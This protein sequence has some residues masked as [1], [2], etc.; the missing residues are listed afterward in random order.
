MAALASLLARMGK[1]VSGS[2]LAEG[3][4][5]A[6]LR[7][8]GITVRLG[9]HPENVGDAEYVVRSSAIPDANPEVRASA[10][11][12]VPSVKLAEAVGEL[13][14][15]RTGVAIAGTHGKTTTTAL[16]AWI[17]DQAG[18]E[19]TALVGADALNF[20][21]SAL[22]GDGPMVVEADEFDRRFLHLSPTVAVVT[23]V[24]PDHLDYFKDL[25]EIRATFQGFVDRLPEDGRLVTCLD[26]ADAARLRTRAD[27]Q[28][29]GFDA[30]ADWR[31]TDYV[32]LEGGGS[33]FTLHNGG[34][35]WPAES[36]LLGEHNAAN[37][38]AALAVADYFGVGLQSAL[39]SLR[40]F[41]GTRRRFE[42]KGRSNGIWV[43]D[44]YA[45]HPTAVAATLRAAR[46]AQRQRPIWVVF[47]P[48]TTNR[49]AALLDEFARAFGDADHVLV[50]PIYR[51]SGRE[52][53]ARPVTSVDLVERIARTGHPDVRFVDTFDEAASAVC[54]AVRSGDLVLTMGAGDVTALSDRLVGELGTT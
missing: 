26:Q 36:G 17:L 49:T 38:L 8:S 45:H 50:L 29:Y 5:I 7:A 25:A 40:H 2:D 24:E 33:R 37:A 23:S 13:M 27:R 32:A 35:S 43:V 19:P 42:T 28:T 1:V 52:A 12:H 9:H 54:A 39:A 16:V 15:G 41:R 14:L 3:P 22:L 48:H 44:D 21:S 31:A 10:R 6:A 46:G 51:P 47:Q 53:A 18:L 30:A 20:G 4:A 11:R 34:R